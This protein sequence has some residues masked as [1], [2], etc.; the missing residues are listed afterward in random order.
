MVTSLNARP[1]SMGPRDRRPVRR[2]LRIR[3]NGGPACVLHNTSSVLD[4]TL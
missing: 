3:R 4:V 1:C 2:K